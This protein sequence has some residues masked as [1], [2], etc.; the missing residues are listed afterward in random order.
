MIIEIIKAAEE[1]RDAAIN[2]AYAEGYKAA[3][4]RY[5]PEVEYLKEQNKENKKSGSFVEKLT[6]TFSGFTIGVVTMIL[7]NFSN[8]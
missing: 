2:E 7:Y 5:A 1:E 8:K 4:L 6:F 3:S